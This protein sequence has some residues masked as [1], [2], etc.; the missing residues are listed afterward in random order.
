MKIISTKKAFTLIELLVVITIMGILA[1]GA[2]SIY[3]SQIQKARDSTRITDIN[4]LRSAI[5]QVYQDNSEY[6]RSNNFLEWGAWQTWVKDYMQS[7]PSDSKHGQ[8]CNT[9]WDTTTFWVDCWYAYIAGADANGIDYWAYEISTAF[10]AEWN[11][12]TRAVWDWWQDNLRYESWIKLNDFDT[13]VKKEAI[14]NVKEW[15]CLPSWSSTSDWDVLIIINWDWD[16][17]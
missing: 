9:S 14:I 10:E 4:A 6:P 17:S 5:E 12:E 11:V 7:I 2:T 8:P 3:T 15:A 13:T 16:C 1:T